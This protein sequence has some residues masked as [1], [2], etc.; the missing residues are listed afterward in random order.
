MITKE[1]PD[2]K[3]V[4]DVVLTYHYDNQDSIALD[5]KDLMTFISNNMDINNTEIETAYF[6]LTEEGYLHTITAAGC[7]KITAKGIKYM[8][9]QIE[10]EKLQTLEKKQSDRRKILEYLYQKLEGQN[11]YLV[12]DEVIK[13]F[14]DSYRMTLKEVESAL[15][16]LT[17][18][19]L[20]QAF[21]YLGITITCKGIREVENPIQPSLITPNSLTYIDNKVMG[22]VINNG[23][24]SPFNN[25]SEV[26]NSFNQ[27]TSEKAKIVKEIEQL[28]EH[29]DKINP[30]STEEEKLTCIKTLAKPELKSRVISAFKGATDT[31]I[32]EYI[33]ESK[34]LKVGK[35]FIKGL[36]E[37]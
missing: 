3:F 36:I 17:N 20:I 10:V 6:Y 30:N 26:T 12:R 32:D 11:S 1:Q 23:D 9:D 5:K 31:F 22:D 28:I 7:S 8:E 18:E 4:R 34:S 16:W 19:N 21:N 24:H 37:G 2:R 15:S 33:L 35:S 14:V 25:R 29:L 27:T 13:L